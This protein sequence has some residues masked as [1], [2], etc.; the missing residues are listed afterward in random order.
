MA[1]RSDDTR[2]RLLDA[3]GAEFAQYGI[4]GARVD[5]IAVAAGCNKQAIYAYFG[6]KEGLFDAVYDRMCVQT[7]DAVPIDVRDLPGYATRL[8]DWFAAHP[9]VLRLATWYQLEY[10]SSRLPPAAA[11]KATEHK[12]AA[13]RAAQAAGFVTSR[14]APE[15]LLALV[16]KLA[17]TGAKDAPEAMLTSA[18]AQTVRQAIADAVARLVTP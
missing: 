1:R 5:R 15:A 14:F 9:E 16:L 17:T 13:I 7:I 10:G 3:A 18:S 11:L 4:A 8:F 12:I 2:K 6:S